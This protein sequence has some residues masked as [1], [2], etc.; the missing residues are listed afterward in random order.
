[1]TK[2]YYL[3]IL[4]VAFFF[5]ITT[6]AYSQDEPVKKKE[7]VNIIITQSPKII[8]TVES[9]LHNKCYDDSKGSI[10]ISAKGGFPPYKYYWSHGDSA[11]DVTSL[12]AGKYRVAVYDNFSCSDTVN[13]VINHPAA[14]QAN[15]ESI[16][17]I[18]CYGYNQGEID[19]TVE[20]GTPPYR[21]NWNNGAISQDIKGVTS[22]RYS[23]LITDAN[24]C[25]EIVTADVEEKPLIIRSIDDVV[26]ILCFGDETGKID[27]SVSGGVGP[28]Q[29]LWSNGETTEDLENLKA[30]TYDVTVQDAQGCTEVSTAKVI[31][32][33]ILAV[34]FD[35]VQNIQCFGDNGGAINIGVV[36]GVEPYTYKWSTGETTQDIA[37]VYAGEYS[38]TITDANQCIGELNTTI[39]EPSKLEVT[40]VNSKDVSYHSGSDGAVDIGVLGG[41]PPYKYKWNNGSTTQDISK[42][43]IGNY[44]ARVSDATGCSAVINVTINQP[45]PL[46][47]QIDK[48]VNIDCNGSSNGEIAI[49]VNGGVKPYNYSWSNGDTNED[50]SAL[51]AGK[52]AVTI[53]DA[54]G[55]KQFVDTILSQPPVFSAKLINI[56]DINCNGNNE[57]AIDIEVS[58]G[59]PPYKYHWSNGMITQDLVD[60]PAGTYTVKVVDVNRCEQ[61]VEASIKQPEKMLAEITQVTH[62]ACS[63]QSTGAIDF[64]VSGGVLPYKYVWNNG[65]SLQDLKTI[66]SGNYSVTVTDAKGCAQTLDTKIN[67]PV[68]LLIQEERISNIDCFGNNSGQIALIVSGGVT[69]YNYVW[70]SGDSVKNISQ[71]KAGKYSISVTDANG[72]SISYSK[73]LTQPSRLQASLGSVV[74]NL[75]FDDKKGEVNI[76]IVGGISPYSY[77]WSSGAT[78]QDLISLK[79]G[80]Y[81][82]EIRDANKC[83]DS[84]TA[85]V[86]ENPLLESTME[87]KNISCNGESSGAINLTVKG[88]I[89]PYIYKWSNGAVT[90]DVLN[91]K[92][93]QYTVVVTDSKGCIKQVDGHVIEPSRFVAILESQE[94]IKCFGD[95]SGRINIKVAGGSS[96][97]TFKWSNGATTEDLKDIA[98]GAYSLLVSDNNGC[99]ETIRAV[100]TQPTRVSYAVKSVTNLTCNKDKSGAIDISITGGVGPYKYSWSNGATTQDLVNV[101]AGKY[102]VSISEANGCTKTLEATVTEPPLLSV[103]TDGVTHIK[104]NGNNTGA[105][106]ISVTGGAAPY[107]Y[108]WS[109]GSVRQDVIGLIAG[110]YSVSVTDANGCVKTVST[111]IKEPAPFVAS[112]LSVKNILCS[113]ENTGEVK[114]RVRGGARPYTFVWN[115][116]DTT[117]NLSAKRAGLYSVRITDKN[118]CSQAVTARITQPNTLV[119]SLVTSNNVACYSGSDGAINITVVGGAAPYKYN[120]SNGSKLQDQTDIPAGTYSVG[121]TDANGCKDSTIV[122]TITQPERLVASLGN[123][124]HIDIYGLSTGAIDVAVSGGSP[125]Y[126]YSWSNGAVTQNIRA[127]PAGNYSVRVI[128]NQGCESIVKTLVRQPPSLDVK[129]ASI[130]NILCSYNNSG[131]ITVSVTGGV[132]PYVF[133][134]NSGDSTQN[135]SNIV[136]GDYSL[137]VSDASGHRKIVN[138]K[139]S[140]PTQINVTVDNLTHILCQG[141]ESGSVIVSVTGGV[142]PYKYNWDNG[143]TTK[144]LNNV[145]AG[146][147]SLKIT[148]KNGCLDSLQVTVNEPDIMSAKIV[149]TINISCNGDNK[150][151]VQVEV[152]GGVTPYSYSWNNGS[153]TRDISEVLA[154]NYIVKITDANGCSRQL[155]TVISEPPKLISSI[156]EV[157]DNLCYGDENGQINLNVS[158][159]VGTYT[160]IWSHGDSTRNVSGLV[161]GEYRVI[162]RDSLGCEQ[163]LSAS[164]T[165]PIKLLAE[166][167]NITDVICNGENNGSVEI[168]VEGGSSPYTYLWS[169]QESNQN[170]SNAVAG[171]YTVTIKDAK[172]CEINV[173]AEIKQPSVLVLT[174]GTVQDNSCAFENKGLVDIT[175]SGGVTPY[176][177]SWSNGAISEDLVNV[178]SDNYSVQVKDAN[179]CINSLTA[180]V[181]EPDLLTVAV[182]SITTLS[183]NGDQN[184]FVGLKVLGGVEPYSYLWNTGASTPSLIDVIAGEYQARISDKNGCVTNITTI[185]EQPT[186]LIKTIDAITDIRC[187]GDSTGAIHV[188]A[189]EGSAPYQFEWSNGV[190]TADNTSLVAGTYKLKITEAN[191]CISTLEATIEQP[192]LFAIKLESKKD[193][194]CFNTEVGAID[195]SVTGGVEPYRFAWSNGATTEDISDVMADN[196]SVMVTDA[197]GCLNTINT[198][199]EHPEELALKIDSVNNVKCCGDSSGAIYISVSGGVKP[200]DYLWSSGET[201]QDIEN[202]ILGQYTV[203]VTDANGCIITTLDD[204]QLNL[205]EQIV[206]QGKFTTRDILFDVA[207]ATIKAESFRTINKIATL[208]KEHPDLTFRIDGHTDSDGAA[209]LNLKLSEDRAI[210]I[211]RALIK[212]GIG[213]TRI[214]TQGWGEVQ[215][216]ASNTTQSGKAQ[217]RRVEFIS[218]TG[219][220]SGT[221]IEN[222]LQQEPEE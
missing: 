103:K 123:V 169:N 102:S 93:G 14:L 197:N 138:A 157:K 177:Y 150:G 212:F 106:A 89:A 183:C 134:W 182:D 33:D 167:V 202:L 208:M 50:L 26:N 97:Y 1:M 142:S 46:I 221:M 137:T 45:A 20:G 109:H 42:L 62:V 82:V 220:L 217:N 162:V 184:G 176:S 121:I 128:D 56:I 19:I 198:K 90:Q 155:S 36:G 146:S 24:N 43:E 4:S 59:L 52:Y 185:I 38:V 165:A 204:E 63:G 3:V 166:V 85:I 69:P 8:V 213:E 71:L 170:L 23:V 47:V 160:Y 57:G 172:G 120:W 22:G 140:E 219:T 18:L 191:G 152:S 25:Q 77:R 87:I 124:S 92:T 189:L 101:G 201:T 135:I 35:V 114:L 171:N 7:G 96:P 9:I 65:S 95:T 133:A 175:V 44:S 115:S 37:G 34:N 161:A 125:S 186:A 129:V 76:N 110:K 30:G 187:N 209:A 199:I 174:L 178:I 195:I 86:K 64:T 180:I 61:Q 179:G 66:P 136:A 194:A 55:F 91:L 214:Y 145:K 149:N 173:T 41:V 54:N 99:S 112:L 181:K 88:G 207:K 31:G 192:T 51:K 17:D 215:P 188:T 73:T 218:L 148:D 27:I 39:I 206:T 147:Y 12:K 29:F 154:G 164:I 205:Y 67:E 58:G 126:K 200:Y 127:I 21:Y 2:N 158:G 190:K 49:T 83:L 104:C 153:R 132:K 117:Q 13:V 72:C 203:N 98:A 163:R 143:K 222:A 32:P 79:S 48:A 108:S 144:D 15:I 28:Y 75:C 193:V 118:G 40:L 70:N 107:K 141:D 53:T 210:S 78:S 211:K 159:G 131:A 68:K 6:V 216:I 122:V 5:G 119:A 168:N 94:D 10:D 113:G 11:Q 81:Q 151:E 16:K 100:V 80:Q 139:V 74:D 105:I 84:L 60:V 111:E 116:G 130:K 196:Y 156:A